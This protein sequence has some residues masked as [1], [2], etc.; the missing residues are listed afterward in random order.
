MSARSIPLLSSDPLLSMSQ[1]NLDE[2]IETW[3]TENA[4]VTT[5]HRFAGMLA[6]L[7]GAV[8]SFCFAHSDDDRRIPRNWQ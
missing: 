4:R 6:E 8:T 3:P 7:F 2:L 1:S 5:V